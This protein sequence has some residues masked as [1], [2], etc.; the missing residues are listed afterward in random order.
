[1]IVVDGA[2]DLPSHM[3]GVADVRSAA[4]DVCVGGELFAGSPDDFWRALRSA[5]VW[6]RVVER[7]RPAGLPASSAD[8]LGGHQCVGC[9]LRHD[10]E[11]RVDALRFV[12]DLD[13]Q[14]QSPGHVRKARGAEPTGGA[15]AFDALPDRR[16]AE[17]LVS[18]PLQQHLPHAVVADAIVPGRVHQQ[19]APVSH[20]G[21]CILP[22]F[23]GSSQMAAMVSPD[24]AVGLAAGA[25]RRLMAPA[26]GRLR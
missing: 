6:R 2:V 13:H 1:M 25:G 3:V 15:E 19:A 7:K 12:D 5:G 14:G 8:R 10:V 16:T 24:E 18:G 22:W 17:P 21:H 26:L 20:L 4:A 9:D 11:E 23:A